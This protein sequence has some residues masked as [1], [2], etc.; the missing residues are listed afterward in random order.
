MDVVLTPEQE[1]FRQEVRAFAAEAVTP[2][3]LRRTGGAI[4][5]FVPEF[6]RAVADHGWIGVQW[7]REYGGQGRTPVDMAVFFEEMGRALAPL[8]RYVGSTVFVGGSIISYGR[9]DQR[10]EFLGRIAAGDLLGSFALTEPEAGSDAAALRTTAVRDGDHYV[11]DGEKVFISGAELADCILTAV[12][13][14]PAAGK[15]AGISLLLVPGDAPGL[16]VRPLH[17]VAGLRVN[18]VVYDGVRVPADRLLGTEG[19]GWAHLQTTFGLERSLSSAQLVG[20]LFRLYR[21]LHVAATAEVHAGRLE[22]A[23]L[24]DL[25]DCRAELEAARLL[26]YRACWLDQNGAMTLDEAAV[27]KLTRSEL[28]L[29]LATVGLDLLGEV[30]LVAGPDGVLGGRLEALYRR[31]QFYITAGGTNDIQRGLLAQ[32]GLGLPRR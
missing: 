23:R 14:D 27:C 1:A 24:A 22:P 18:V 21:D 2:E 9:P 17:T 10:A 7:P 12:R 32:R 15:Y 26:S 3:L 31:A 20:S 6:H 16:S 30:G 13:T 25:H 29:R 28:A 8:G 5:A 4:E 19:N 11:V